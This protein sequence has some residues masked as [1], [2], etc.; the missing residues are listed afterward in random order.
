[1]KHTTE[2]LARPCNA[3]DIFLSGSGLQCGNCLAYEE[4]QGDYKH[5]YYI[6]G[7]LSYDKPPKF[8]FKILELVTASGLFITHDQTFDK[9]SSAQAYIRSLK[10]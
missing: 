1:M 2:G 4:Y 9:L 6:Q 7:N 10:C 5:S 3:N 8:Y